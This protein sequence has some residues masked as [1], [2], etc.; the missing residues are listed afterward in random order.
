MRG[1]ALDLGSAEQRR[2][3]HRGLV[4]V[5]DADGIGAENWG[6]SATNA[7]QTIVADWRETVASVLGC[8]ASEL[9]WVQLDS[10]GQFDHVQVSPTAPSHVEWTPVTAAGHPARSAAAF[11][12]AFPCIGDMVLRRLSVMGGVDLREPR[13]MWGAV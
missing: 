2:G 6:A 11:R 4:L 3:I 10:E 13:T 5:V 9:A 7:M 12:A 8:S 1:A